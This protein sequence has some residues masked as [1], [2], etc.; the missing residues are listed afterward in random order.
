MDAFINN[1]NSRAALWGVVAVT[2]MTAAAVLFAISGVRRAGAGNHAVTQA[3]AIAGNS[4]GTSGGT[5]ASGPASLPLE[6]LGKGGKHAGERR[7]LQTC[8]ICHGPEGLGQP[9][10]GANLRDSRFVREQSDAALVSFVK[11]GRPLGDPASVL[12]L[13]M[14]PMGGNPTLNEGQ[15]RDIVSFL[16]TLQ[17]PQGARAGLQ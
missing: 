7:Y 8:A 13:S 12:G 9:H 4:V 3:G 15:I 11:T 14:P 17:G 1:I 5:Y 10:M 6:G 2:A 16:R